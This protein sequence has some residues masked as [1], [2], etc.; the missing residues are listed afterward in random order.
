MLLR[1]TAAAA[2]L[3]LA[4]GTVAGDEGNG[5]PGKVTAEERAAFRR[6]Q[7]VFAKYC[8]S[9]HSTKTG[10]RKKK[11]LAHLGMDRYPFTGHHAGEAGEA[12]REALGASGK[13]PTMPD[14]DPGA[15]RG[16]ELQLVLDW[17]AAFDRAHG[18]L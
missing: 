3:L 5:L 8:Y 13:E 9:C 11:A 6:A 7:P 1:G 10:H 4:I 17:A 16:A 14:D 18:A 12:I 15:V 2:L